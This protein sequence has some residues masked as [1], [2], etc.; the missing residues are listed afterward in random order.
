[1]LIKDL[2]ESAFIERL[3]AI[4]PG[5]GAELGIGDDTAVCNVPP[6]HSILY[7]SDLVAENTHFIRN[8]HPPDSIGYKVIAVN[9]SDVG[10]MGGVPL[11]C[12]LSIA[13]PGELEVS[14]LDGFIAGLERACREFAVA[15][16]GGDTSSA[17]RIFADVS[18]IGCVESGREVRRSG[19]KPGDGIFVTGCLGGS[20]LGLERLRRGLP[21]TE[22]HLYPAPRHKVGKRVA[23][24]AHAMIDVSDG[25]ST[26]LA[27]ILTESRVSARLFGARIPVAEGASRDQALHGGEE[28]ELLIVA[29][30]LPGEVE[31][32]SVTR[33]GE[34]VESS[35]GHR[36]LLVDS[37]IETVLTP[38]GYQHF[39][40]R[41]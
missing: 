12:T 23:V 13:L 39:H 7:C 16:V 5:T 3:R 26:D 19:A 27:H 35:G 4:F 38:L 17:E 37:A 15:L 34:I 6:G 9:V 22:R 21:G 25:L 10:A 31:G 8:L 1:M 40:S 36:I 29:A 20:A 24:Q 28:Y 2:G 14:W 33:I 18:M 11:F 32:V 30:E 41:P